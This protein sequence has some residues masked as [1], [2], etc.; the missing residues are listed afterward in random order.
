GIVEDRVWIG[1]DRDVAGVAWALGIAHRRGD[2][3]DRPA[4]RRV[5]APRPVG[6]GARDGGP[7]RAEPE[8]TDA[9]RLGAHASGRPHATMPTTSKRMRSMWCR[10]RTARASDSK[11]SARSP[12]VAR[13]S[14]LVLAS[15][16]M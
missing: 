7:D 3:L 6:E 4:C 9:E 1:R 10:E 13:E 8:E 5:D 2:E 15:I 11:A 12:S 14:E 16:A